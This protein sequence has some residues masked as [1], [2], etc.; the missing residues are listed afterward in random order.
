MKYKNIL[1]LTFGLIMWPIIIATPRVVDSYFIKLAKSEI[2]FQE[3]PRADLWIG[4]FSG[5][6]AALLFIGFSYLLA[7]IISLIKKSSIINGPNIFFI[8]TCLFTILLIKRYGGKV[9]TALL[10]ERDNVEK[11]QDKIKE[12]EH[13]SENDNK[14]F[15]LW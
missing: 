11:I 6:F 9:K 13:N 4:I 10:L 14:S 2:A 15:I 8:A 7:L 5:L 3:I 1:M 12:F